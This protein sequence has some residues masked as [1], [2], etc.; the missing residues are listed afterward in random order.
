MSNT[1]TNPIQ[2][3]AY[4]IN[5]AADVIGLGRDGIYRAISEGR[6][7]A[8][9]FGKRTLILRTDAEAFLQAL[10]FKA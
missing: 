8:R 9:K 7:R 10:P 5:E 3:A 1:D 4:S 6:L 2:P